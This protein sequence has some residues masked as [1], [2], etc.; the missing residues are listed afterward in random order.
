M[1]KDAALFPI[2]FFDC[3]IFCE[4]CVHLRNFRIF[5]Q[6]KYDKNY[7]KSEIP[8]GKPLYCK[9][10]VCGTPVIYATGEFA[11]LQ[12]DPKNGFSKIWGN[13]SPETGDHIF[14]PEHGVC[15]VDGVDR[16]YG[17][18][19]YV[20]LKNQNDEKIKIQI[21]N[22][23]EESENNLGELYRLLPQDA[24]NAR[25]GDSVY[26]TKTGLAG[27][28][29]GLEF[30]GMQSVIVKFEDGKIVRCHCEDNVYYLPDDI[31]RRNAVWRCRDLKFFHNLEI[32]SHSK[33]LN[34][35]CLAP[36][37]KSVRKLNRII[38]SIPQIR[39]FIIHVD[40]RRSRI[41]SNEIHKELIKN[42]IY[43]C[44][45]NIQVED[46]DIYIS[47]FYSNREIPKNIYRILSKYPVKKI[48]L[49]IK[50]R[51][52]MKTIRTINEDSHFIK[53]NKI[54][55][56]IHIDGWVGSEKE[57]RKAKFTAFFCSPSFR[58]ANHLWVI[59]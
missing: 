34:V 10:D 8:P 33:I 38:S 5:S 56:E 15:T 31:I 36:D 26:H 24:E 45:C 11:E 53:I 19:P 21:E 7:G 30:N 3:G 51:T 29:I 16:L 44:C 23:P 4:K 35:T 43:I 20:T 59:S 6:E 48:T 32:S 27:K 54:G 47:G 57:K 46:Q 2:H 9:C 25:I 37:F 12:E 58:I 18:S 40:V 22:P 55:K 50:M 41:D 1:S 28:V 14:H 39:C 13:G 52:D 49:D 42:C 17:S